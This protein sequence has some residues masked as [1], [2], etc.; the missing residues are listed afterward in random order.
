MHDV[1]F[2]SLGALAALTF[3]ACA[4]AGD[5]TDTVEP[6]VGELEALPAV[7]AIEVGPQVLAPAETLRYRAFGT[8]HR[9]DGL[10]A[11]EVPPLRARFS[12][13]GDQ[14][15]LD[16]DIAGK[17]ATVPL[18]PNGRVA[19]DFAGEPLGGDLY[20]VL[21]PAG[22]MLAIG[23]PY[24]SAG[25]TTAYIAA[26]A[27]R[28]SLTS[29]E[30]VTSTPVQAWTLGDAHLVRVETRAIQRLYWLEDDGRIRS[31]DLGLAYLGVA[32]LLAVPGQGWRVVRLMRLSEGNTGKLANDVTMA[33]LR[34]VPHSEFVACAESSSVADSTLH[35]L[36]RLASSAVPELQRCL[37]L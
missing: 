20:D 18:A 37:D 10:E 17:V 8:R 26:N 35:K 16:L 25:P 3:C 24:G 23:K 6:P 5:P 28:G 21:P 33:D 12:T 9:A 1:R 27:A 31:Q 34:Q 4:S 14:V 22:T 11:V 13:R 19:D 32:D 15:Q 7:S 29:D 2:S 30:Q 36:S